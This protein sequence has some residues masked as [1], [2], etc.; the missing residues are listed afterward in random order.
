MYT[1]DTV[2]NVRCFYA[3]SVELT[4]AAAYSTVAE[5]YRSNA[6]AVARHPLVARLYRDRRRR[7]LRRPAGFSLLLSATEKASV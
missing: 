4:A 6:A 7:R 2:R 5:L 1:T 3:K